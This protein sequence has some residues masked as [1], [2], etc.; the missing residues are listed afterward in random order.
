MSQG[1]VNLVTFSFLIVAR[2]YRIQVDDR[3]VEKWLKLTPRR[4]SGGTKM[5][6]GL[7]EQGEHKGDIR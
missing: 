7:N 2:K 3:T 5:F 6:R 1:P 4:K